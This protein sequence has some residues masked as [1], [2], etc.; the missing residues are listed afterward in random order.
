MANLD[1]RPWTLSEITP[2]VRLYNLMWMGT[3]TPLDLKMARRFFEG[4]QKNPDH[5][6]YVAVM[7]GRIVGVFSLLVDK[8]GKTECGCRVRLENVA[9]HP[10][11]RGQGIGKGIIRFVKK[12]CRDVGCDTVLHATHERRAEANSFYES[13]GFKREGYYLVLKVNE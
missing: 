2:V 7:E 9:V 5:D 8:V 1:I 13:L 12:R 10:K 3:G 6:M 11:Y 4:V